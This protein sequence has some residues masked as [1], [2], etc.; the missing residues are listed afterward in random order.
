MTGV[1]NVR[2]VDKTPILRNDVSTVA[3]VLSANANA[4]GTVME[5]ES[6]TGSTVSASGTLNENETDATVSGTEIRNG[7]ATET[8]NGVTGIDGTKKIAIEKAGRT[9]T[10][11][12]E[13]FSPLRTVLSLLDR[14][15]VPQP[16][17]R[18]SSGS[19][20]D[21]SMM[22]YVSPLFR[23]CRCIHRFLVMF[24]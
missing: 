15:I 9:V 22:T 6:G 8:A 24:V 7:I 20:E 16:P 18:T 17:L 2:A 10:S 14:V 3:S 5:T 11:V 4:A 1:S 19:E 21:L 23:A 12:V 13:L